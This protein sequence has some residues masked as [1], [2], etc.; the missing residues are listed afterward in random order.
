MR[1]SA[2][3]RI[4][5][6]G[7]VTGPVQGFGTKVTT[8]WGRFGGSAHHARDG[9]MSCVLTWN[10]FTEFSCLRVPAL[11]FKPDDRGGGASGTMAHERN[12]SFP[13]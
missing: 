11:P 3:E 8:I 9:I 13:V 5:T 12:V 1:R 10:M 7:L 6:E 2:G 4:L